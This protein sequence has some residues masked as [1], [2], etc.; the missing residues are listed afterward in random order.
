MTN[1][2]RNVRAMN[3]GPD[4][5]FQ[6][7]LG[8]YAGPVDLL[9]YLVRRSEV[10]ISKISLASLIGQ[11]RE[12]IEVLKEIDIDGVG[13]FLDV[14]SLLIEWK[15][16]TVLPSA[17]G[18]EDSEMDELDPREDLVHRLMMYK[19]FRDVSLLLGEHAAQWRCRHPRLVNDLPPRQISLRDQP[20]QEVE[21]WDLVSSFGR[22][23]KNNTPV[24]LGTSIVLDDTP[25][26]TWMNRI[27][28]RL[29]KAGHASFTDLFEPGMHKSS[30]VGIFLAILELVRHHQ[31]RAEQAGDHGDLRIFASEN[32]EAS[33]PIADVSDYRGE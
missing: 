23:L 5:G 4:S 31:V 7:N 15:M 10:E 21:L 8:E 1:A 12:Y 14:A 2:N 19:D 28:D 25:I 17:G 32:F 22:I 33:A 20:L 11:Y 9:L 29:A 27:H 3:S 13:D 24:P 18:D 16:R 6:V 26:Q 30:M